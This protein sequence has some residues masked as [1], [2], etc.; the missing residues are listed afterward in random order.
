MIIRIQKR[1]N[2]FVQI[3]KRPLEDERLSWK[4]KGL[5]AHLLCKP[6]TWEISVADLV[7]RSRDGREAVQSALRELKQ[8]GYATLESK[9]GDGGRL[10]G[11]TWVIYELPTDGKPVFR[12]A[13]DERENRPTGKPSNG[14]TATSNNILEERIE[15]EGETRPP[16]PKPQKEEKPVIAQEIENLIKA[17]PQ[18]SPAELK[19]FVLKEAIK[20]HFEKYPLNRDLYTT[21]LTPVPTAREFLEQI[22]IYVRHYSAE[23]VPGYQFFVNDPVG[24]IPK[25][26]PK[27]LRRWASG[28]RD[29]LRRSGATS[30]VYEKPKI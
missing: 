11:K 25:T 5:L 21:G 16:E 10:L 8:L 30:G 4:A 29:E 20:R 23:S 18:V 22:D 6:D 26:F 19:V 12:L 27:W 9:R 7:S 28:K 1:D 3:D 17:N 13:T 14:K 15:Q 24:H 2:P